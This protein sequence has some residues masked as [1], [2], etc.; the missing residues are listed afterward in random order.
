MNIEEKHDI[1]SLLCFESL[2]EAAATLWADGLGRIR[3]ALN[4]CW[5]SISFWH[6]HLNGNMEVFREVLDIK[7]YN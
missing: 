6:F 3:V 2:I 5:F 4:P 7:D 1:A